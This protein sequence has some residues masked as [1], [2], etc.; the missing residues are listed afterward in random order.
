MVA[1]VESQEDVLP[2]ISLREYPT[3]ESLAK[4]ML[5]AC[6]G[7]GFFYLT[8]HGLSDADIDN[9]FGIAGTF[10]K[11]DEEEKLKYRRGGSVGN[12]VSFFLARISFECNIV[13]S[14]RG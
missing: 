12:I 4:P 3:P 9:I 10:F 7:P 2:T 5:D 13:G 11:Y 8:D 14:D 1:L 6:S